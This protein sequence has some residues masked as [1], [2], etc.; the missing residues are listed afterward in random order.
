MRR[1]IKVDS[2]LTLVEESNARSVLLLLFYLHGGRLRS[3]TSLLR[4]LL[5]LIVDDINE[6]FGQLRIKQFFGPP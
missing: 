6:V 1:V 5:A 3:S 4:F 2:D